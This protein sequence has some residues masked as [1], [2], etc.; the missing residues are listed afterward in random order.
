MLKTVMKKNK[1]KKDID[2]IANLAQNFRIINVNQIKNKYL[3]LTMT[4]ASGKRW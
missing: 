1:N 3:S 2:K 4:V